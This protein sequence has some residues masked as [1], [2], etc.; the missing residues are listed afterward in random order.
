[1]GDGE[2]KL[3]GVR[4]AAAL[5]GAT[6]A[7]PMWMPRALIAQGIKEVYGEPG[8]IKA[9]VVERYYD[10]SRRP[11][12]RR[13]MME[14]FRVL[15]KVNKEELH[16]TLFQRRGPKILLTP[17]GQALYELA[18]PLVEAMDALPTSFQASRRGLET[19]RLSLAAGEST[20]LYI[21]PEFLR[22]FVHAHPG[23]EL[24]L[25]NVT[26]L[27][28][29]KLLRN[30]TVDLAV[31]SLIEVPDDITYQPA[32]R[33]DPMLIHAPDHPLSKRPRVMLKDVA[34]YPLIL[35]PQ[36]LT[37]WR[38]V[39]YVFRTHN[40]RYRVALEAG[41]WEV[42]KK[43]VALGLGVSIV[44]GVCLTGSEPLV[45]LP[46]DRYFPRRTYG[47]VLRKGKLLPSPAARFIE[48]ITRPADP[49]G[50]A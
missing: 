12:N 46:F 38:I 11:G 36:H 26:G 33:Y 7:M 27:D 25:H 13:G 34:A 5:P 35:P 44:T 41:G 19:G 39:D 42:I 18:R 15:L 2:R 30:D 37:T 14:I 43:Y 29:L 16:T 9:G 32:F 21:L 31:G 1:M 45:A 23:V 47:I 17:D 40:L 24:K 49:A 48:L 6:V 3:R 4:A 20:I 8:R 10:L 50:P 28:G 22:E